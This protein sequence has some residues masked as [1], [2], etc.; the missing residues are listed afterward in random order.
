M[1][2]EK[3]KKRC[4]DAKFVGC[5]RLQGYRL[6]FSLES[7]FWIWK[8]GV[9][10]I[11]KDTESEVWGLVYDLSES[12]LKLLDRY[13]EAPKIYRR[14]SVRIETPEGK[15]LPDAWA[16]EVINK[17]EFVAPSSAYLDI[18]KKAAEKHGFPAPY[19]A[20]LNTITTRD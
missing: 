13:E 20:F 1:D 4:P 15:I 7:E 16:Y 9:G 10:D 12:D 8:G 19:R 18:I 14:I 5:A 6:A 2:I 11:A 3:M 17:K